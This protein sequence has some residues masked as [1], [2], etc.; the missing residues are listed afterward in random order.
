MTD[1]TFLLLFPVLFFQAPAS[2]SYNVVKHGDVTEIVSCKDGYSFTA[3]KN[4]HVASDNPIPYMYV[5]PSKTTKPTQVGVPDG[6]AE[7]TIVNDRDAY[8]AGSLD[9]WI[10]RENSRVD[11]ASTKRETYNAS[12]IIPNAIEVVSFEDDGD[13]TREKLTHQTEIFFQF[14]GQLLA[15]ILR[16]NANDPKS[17]RYE[18]ALKALVASFREAEHKRK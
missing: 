5:P 13:D 15:A 7:I 11:Y 4:W 3:P 12:A 1:L 17:L 2:R 16:F 14:N 9:K 18:K 6:S 10:E 8:G